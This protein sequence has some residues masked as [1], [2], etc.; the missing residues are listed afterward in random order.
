MDEFFKTL[1]DTPDTTDQ[2][3]PEDIQANKGAA[4]AAC[5]GFLFWIPLVAAKDSP[6]A[7]YYAN[8]GLIFFITGFV[9]GIASGI[10]SWLPFIGWILSLAISLVDLGMFIF[11]L[12]NAA[13]GKAKELPIV[14]GLVTF[15]K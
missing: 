7:K 2:Y 12:V 1:L 15:F 9:L 8:Q 4:I 14:G 5:F 10:V 3:A 11:L 13:N 6:F